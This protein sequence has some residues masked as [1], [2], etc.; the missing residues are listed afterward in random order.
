[1]ISII[2]STRVTVTVIVFAVTFKY[3]R[4]HTERLQFIFIKLRQRKYSSHIL[5]LFLKL[6]I[7][8]EHEKKIWCVVKADYVREGDKPTGYPLHGGLY[9]GS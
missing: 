6:R 3:T 8:I 4:K 2:K 5:N 7:F 1:M 9:K